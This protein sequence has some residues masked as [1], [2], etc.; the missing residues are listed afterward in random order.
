MN[1]EEIT[2]KSIII[3]CNYHTTW[4]SKP[5]MRFILSEVKGDRARL[6]TRHTR[7]NFWTDKSDL[8]FIMSSHN[9]SKANKYFK[10]RSNIK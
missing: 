6:M 9:I 5:G 3:G 8:I 1:R 4:Q 7:K 10:E 2:E